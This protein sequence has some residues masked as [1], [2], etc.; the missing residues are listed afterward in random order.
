MLGGRVRRQFCRQFGFRGAA[1]NFPMDF[2][3]RWGGDLGVDFRTVLGINFVHCGRVFPL[4][5][6]RIDDSVAVSFVRRHPEGVDGLVVT[7]HTQH[8]HSQYS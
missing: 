4:Q 8:A 1:K 7:Y 2:L 3:G 6:L 5:Y